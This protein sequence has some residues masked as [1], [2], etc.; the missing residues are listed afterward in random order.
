MVVMVTNMN[1]LSEGQQLSLLIGT[2]ELNFLSECELEEEG[3]REVEGNINY[4]DYR[5][6]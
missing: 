1:R 6:V 5:L 2:G 4:Y 3:D